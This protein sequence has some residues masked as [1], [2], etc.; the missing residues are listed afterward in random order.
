VTLAPLFL[1]LLVGGGVSGSAP[2]RL[3]LPSPE[4][5]AGGLHWESGRFCRDM[6]DACLDENGNGLF[7][8]PEY[9]VSNLKCR[10]MP[11]ERADCSF[12]SVRKSGNQIAARESCEATFSEFRDVYGKRGWHF[13]RHKRERPSLSSA[14]I[15]TCN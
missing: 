5:V 7:D 11:E 10:R 4:D 14:P 9:E 6:I 2:A 15:L 1:T 8:L 12:I 13:A 3:P